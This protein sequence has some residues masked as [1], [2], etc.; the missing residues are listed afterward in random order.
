[1]VT[2]VDGLMP[3]EGVASKKR[4]QIGNKVQRLMLS[5]EYLVSVVD[6]FHPSNVCH[7]HNNT[8]HV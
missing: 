1:M 7:M 5:E 8:T 2:C 6:K 4:S 3:M